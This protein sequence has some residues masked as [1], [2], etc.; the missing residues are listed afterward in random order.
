VARNGG[1][2]ASGY[3]GWLSVNRL[4]FFAPTALARIVY[5][6]NGM[7]STVNS[8][9]EMSRRLKQAGHD[10]VWLCPEHAAGR[11]RHRGY[12]V[13]IPQIDSRMSRAVQDIDARFAS[14]KTNPFQL[15]RWIASRRRLRRQSLAD[16]EITRL[17][18]DLDPDLLLIDYEMHVAIM[19]T[20]CLRLPTMLPIVWFSVFRDPQLPPLHTTRMPPQS[21]WQ[22]QLN[23]VR[24][25]G[26]A[27]RRVV[28]DRLLRP[29]PVGIRQALRPLQSGW[30]RRAELALFARRQGYDLRRE[31]SQWHWIRPHAYRHLPVLCYNAAELDFPHK[32]HPSLHYV[33]P[34]IDKTAA[35]EA[36]D[37]ESMRRWSEWL[38]R[39]R[40]QQP[41][42]P[43]VYCSLGTFWSVDRSLLNC[44][45]D[46]FRRQPGW[47]LVIGLGGKAGT[48]DFPDVPDNVLILPYAPQ[49]QV[50]SHAEAAITHG[51]I[52]SINEYI[53][54]GLP[55]LVCSTGHVDQP[56]CAARV[57]YHGLGLSLD[58]S[59]LTPERVEAAIQTLLH[60]D[61]TRTRVQKMREVFERY[62]RQGTAER[63]VEQWLRSAAS[64]GSE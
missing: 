50:I 23:R 63:T 64:P 31:T 45:I 11:I 8:G 26:F 29:G 38:A 9:L 7:A 25:L 30:N 24:W 35:D 20:A 60:D 16:D 59:D 33:G 47:Q 14:R 61:A 49:W 44:V 62:R 28:S 53:E 5:I 19:A 4:H 32:P 58:R 40:Q 46:A 51:G 34:M 57:S 54:A 37:P 1:G 42:S 41:K 52:T 6:T 13:R 3:D 36:V 22:T 10:V 39:Y 56:G 18:R 21:A 15:V 12:E 27:V 43:L 17:V 2:E 48:D 55:M